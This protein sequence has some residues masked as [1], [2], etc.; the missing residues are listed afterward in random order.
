M[1]VIGPRLP[2]QKVSLLFVAKGS[3]IEARP[4]YRSHTKVDG[5]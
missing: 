2:H 5:K 4:G 3:C 1:A